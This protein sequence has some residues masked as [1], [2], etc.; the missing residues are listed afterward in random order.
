MTERV[1]IH[2]DCNGVVTAWREDTTIHWI[3]GRGQPGS[4]DMKARTLAEG[5]ISC[6]ERSAEIAHYMMS[7]QSIV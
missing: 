1:T 2:T 6:L 3:D 7:D 5:Y 4:L